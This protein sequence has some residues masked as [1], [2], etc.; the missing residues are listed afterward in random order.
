MRTLTTD[1]ASDIAIHGLQFIAGDPE[2]LS[3]FVALTGIDPGEIR[4]LAGT[5]DFLVAILD[6]FLS[7]EPTLLAFTSSHNIDPT[8]IQAARQA[9]APEE[10]IDI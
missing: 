3:R 4:Q 5:T 9:L 8:H 7:D 1:S 2:Q 6:F 10:V